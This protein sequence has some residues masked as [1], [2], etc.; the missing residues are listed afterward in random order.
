MRQKLVGGAQVALAFVR[1]W[2]PTLNFRQ[3]SQLPSFEGNEMD[4]SPH[5]DVVQDP[6]ARIITQTEVQTERLLRE[7]ASRQ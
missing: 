2:H 4:F 5:Y 7:G 3:T 6:A 1:A